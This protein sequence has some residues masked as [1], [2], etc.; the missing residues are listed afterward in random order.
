[1]CSKW[2]WS[3][4]ILTLRSGERHYINKKI[5]SSFS[6]RF[7]IIDSGKRK[8]L[9]WTN[10]DAF[11]LAFQ[12][13]SVDSICASTYTPMTSSTVQMNLIKLMTQFQFGAVSQFDWVESRFIVQLSKLS[14]FGWAYNKKKMLQLRESFSP[15][16]TRPIFIL[17]LC[18]VES[19]ER[20]IFEH[21]SATFKYFFFS[22]WFD[23][24]FLS[25]DFSSF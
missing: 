8:I 15:M 20:N 25:W 23:W 24:L 13:R 16:K 1:M 22:I 21:S 3:N 5:S 14:C 19:K 2:N 9:R 17:I 10:L 6:N 18:V 7:W 11:L 4:R 12:L